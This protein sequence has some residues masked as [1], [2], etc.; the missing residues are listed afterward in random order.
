MPST[1]DSCVENV[2]GCCPDVEEGSG[3]ASGGRQGASQKNASDSPLK[4]AEGAEWKILS[5]KQQ[6]SLAPRIHAL[7]DAW[8]HVRTPFLCLWLDL[9]EKPAPIGSACSVSI[10]PSIWRV[11][12]AL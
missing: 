6:H 12:Q 2:D 10:W 7:S 9:P 8:A 11:F 1:A 3:R 4:R 5:F